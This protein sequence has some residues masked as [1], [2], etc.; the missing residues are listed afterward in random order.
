MAYVM[1]LRKSHSRARCRETSWNECSSQLRVIKQR[2]SRRRLFCARLNP[3]YPQYI[4]AVLN[5]DKLYE[6]LVC[7][8]AGSATP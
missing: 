2:E 1:V 8:K 6:I 3:W 7:P 4:I 5:H